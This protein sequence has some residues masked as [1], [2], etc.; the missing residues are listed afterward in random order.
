MNCQ[1]GIASQDRRKENKEGVKVGEGEE[2][3][4]ESGEID[5]LSIHS[6]SS[7]LVMS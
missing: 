7:S 5:K 4:R 2:R 3:E 1:S 6:A